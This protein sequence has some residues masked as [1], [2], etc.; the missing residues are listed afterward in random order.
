MK[1]VIKALN[2]NPWSGVIQYRNCHTSLGPYLTRSGR[3]YT[4]L[5]PEDEER[6]GKKLRMDL[7]SSSIFWDTFHVKMSDKDLILDTEDPYDEL[8]YLFLK[9]HKRVANGLADKKATAN[10][11]II[12]EVEEA[13]ELNKYNKQKR[14][15]LKEFDK[16][17]FN[18]MRKCLRLY[19][20]KSDTLDNEIVEQKLGELVDNDPIKFLTMWVENDSRETEFLIG[21]AVAKNVIRKNKNIYKYGTEI[22]GH[23]LAEA[24]TYLDDQQNQDIRLAI[25][26]EIKVK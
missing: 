20:H 10:Y 6:L 8:R 24:V 12:N 15:A 1:V 13:K 21:D 9:G 18:D 3:N 4:G 16:L 2:K 5:T 17:S 19:G 22:V 23:N 26:N 25:M 11:V 14:K 7:S